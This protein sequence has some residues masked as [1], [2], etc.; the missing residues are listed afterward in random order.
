MFVSS[1]LYKGQEII[2]PKK[3]VK[4]TSDKVRQAII[5][6]LQPYLYNSR[7][8]DLFSGTG[9]VGIEAL[10]NNASFVC[11][12]ENSEKMYMLLKKNLERIIPT[13]KKTFY[14]TVKHNALN[15]TSDI[16]KEE[17]GSFD[18][19]FADPFYDNLKYYLDKLHEIAISFLKIN[20]IFILEHSCKEDFTKFKYFVNVKNYGDTCLSIFKKTE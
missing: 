3:G 13:E 1:G 19:V 7:F 4:P 6:I 10:S 8:M 2:V 14:K 15:I 11:F 17:Y 5:N 12:V 16:I 20:G 18:I 9:A